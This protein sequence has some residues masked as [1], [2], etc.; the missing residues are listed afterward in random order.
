MVKDVIPIAK[1]LMGEDET[2]L[3]GEIIKS[4]MLREGH[5]TKQ[6]EKD[7]SHFTGSKYSIAAVNGTA[8]LHVALEALDIQ[9]GEEIITTGFTFIASSNSI[10]FIGAVPIFA[11]IS[12]ETYNIDPDSI[13]QKISKK[14]KAIMPVHIFGLPADM[15]PIMEIAEEYDLYIIEDCAQAHGAKIDGQHVGNFSD[16]ACFSLFATKNLTTGEGGVI[17]TNNEDLAEKCASIKN[18][19][20]GRS[21]ASYEHFRV[22]YN[23]RMTDYTAAIGLTQLQKL[24]KFLKHRNENVQLL[25]KH[26][27]DNPSL[28]IQKIP[29]GFTHAN[30]IMAPVIVDGDKTPQDYISTLRANK[31]SSRTIYDVPAYKQEN[32]LSIKKWRWARFVTYPNY[33]NVS[34][35]VTERIARSHFEVPIHPGVRKDQIEPIAEI[36]NSV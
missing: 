1:P 17:T 21:G 19:G 30:Y 6:F 36:L 25:R 16:I 9:P 24:P 29:K 22:G 32:Y 2:N 12:P 5:Y 3:V 8:A 18:H 20:R 13:R 27:V 15:K 10:L 4:G 34:N 33:S 35:P 26:L 11:D 14:T 28:H 7:F 31:V 23:F